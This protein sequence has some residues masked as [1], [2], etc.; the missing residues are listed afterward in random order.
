M[1]AASQLAGTTRDG[2]AMNLSQEGHHLVLCGIWCL[3]WRASL[4]AISRVLSKKL[5]LVLARRQNCHGEVRS[6]R[7]RRVEHRRGTRELCSGP[8]P[9]HAASPSTATILH[10]ITCSRVPACTSFFTL[11]LKST[12]L[13][14]VALQSST[15]ILPQFGRGGSAKNLIRPDFGS[16]SHA[17]S[18]FTDRRNAKT[19][20]RR[21]SVAILDLR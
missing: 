5:S 18:D 17:S 9:R 16:V 11:S 13:R 3:E 12:R 7:K 20:P 2:L 15:P 14:Y 10:D 1:P 4:Y 8:T 6:R 19:T 21:T